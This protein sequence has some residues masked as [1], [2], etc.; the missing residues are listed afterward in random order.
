MSLTLEESDPRIRLAVMSFTSSHFS[1]AVR[2]ALMSSAKAVVVVAAAAVVVVPCEVLV[3]VEA[4][5]EV[6][7]GVCWAAQGL[8][9]G[10]LSMQ[11]AFFLLMVP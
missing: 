11:Y 6:V 1:I 9:R 2:K 8:T 5:A 10:G 3:M 7:A 4:P